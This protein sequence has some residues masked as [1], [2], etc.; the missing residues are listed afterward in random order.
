MARWFAFALTMFGT[1]LLTSINISFFSL[2]WSVL[3]IA[4]AMWFYFGWKATIKVTKDKYPKA[5]LIAGEAL[6][7]AEADT[8]LI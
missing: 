7:E 1:W 3:G 2:G 4:T 6:T 8:I 5:K